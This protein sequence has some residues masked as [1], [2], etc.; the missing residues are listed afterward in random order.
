MTFQ[1]YLDAL[2]TQVGEHGRKACQPFDDPQS[3]QLGFRSPS[4]EYRISLAAVKG[5]FATGAWREDTEI[6]AL[7]KQAGGT[8]PLSAMTR[9]PPRDVLIVLVQR[10]LIEAMT[11][12]E[13]LY[14][15][16]QNPR[17]GRA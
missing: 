7:Y 2:T 17:M 16:R 5:H 10:A 11:E 3:L 1:E 15:A 4:G 14:Q 8:A 6:L 9:L 13:K 12:G